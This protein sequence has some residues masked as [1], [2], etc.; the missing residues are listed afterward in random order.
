MNPA[1]ESPTLSSE[2]L[3]ATTP[4]RESADTQAVTSAK[5]GASLKLSEISGSNGFLIAGAAKGDQSGIAVSP[6][7]DVNGDGFADIMIGAHFADPNGNL[8]A[9]SGYVVFGAKKGIAITKNLLALD[10]SDGFVMEGDGSL[11]WAGFSVSTAGDVNNDGFDDL[12]VGARFASGSGGTYAGRSYV[13]FGGNGSFPKSIE[14]AK[15]DGSDGFALEGV[16]DYDQSGRSVAAAGDVNNDGIDDLIVGAYLAS[17]GATGKA[18]AAY[19]VFGR[20]SG[21][22]ASLSLSD[23]D[24][25]DGFTVSGASPKDQAGFAVDGAGDVNGDGID[26]LLVGAPHGELAGPTRAGEAFLVL[27]RDSGFAANFDL[28][29]LD[30]SDGTRFLGHI[31]NGE[32]GGAVAVAGDINGDGLSDIVI[33]AP[34]AQA[35]GDAAAGR[36]Y[37]VFGHRGAQNADLDLSDLDGRNGFTLLGIDSE[38]Y[39]G[40]DVSSA[41]DLNGDGF[42]DLLIGAFGADP[43]GASRAGESYIVFGRGDGN[44]PAALKLAKLDGS[45]GVLLKGSDLNDRS[46]HAVAGLGDVNRDGFDDIIVGA[47]SG[48]PNGKSNSGENYVLFGG[49]DF[50][51]GNTTAGTIYANNLSGKAG[52]DVLLGLSGKDRLKGL[53]G[54]DSL[55][56]GDGGDVLLGGLGN[57]QLFGGRAGDRLLGQAGADDLFGNAG[58]DTLMGGNGPDYLDGG[59]GPDELIGGAGPDKLFGGNQNDTLVGGVGADLLFGQ[60]GA[61]RLEG[62]RQN[63]VLRGGPGAD[64]LLGGGGADRLFGGTGPDTI[65]G[66]GGNDQLQG[67]GGPDI[68][69][70]TT[71]GGEDVVTDF[72]SLTDLLDVSDFGFSSAAEVLAAT[73]NDNGSAVITL[74]V[75]ESVTLDGVLKE[76]LDPADFIL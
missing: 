60:G 24:G 45:D 56:G 58:S 12:I 13:V 51:P 63:D 2:S 31:A 22:P 52:A 18:G 5:V 26:D 25:S 42:D 46:G 36:A 59:T 50:V 23:L 39:A 44:F 1:T 66:G 64:D 35:G 43:G 47:R 3:L 27:G 37:V 40:F 28:G 74:S 15:L 11:D 48:D 72:L 20:D 57:D 53:G 61:D 71:G 29:A 54:A 6:A 49:T 55:Y 76:S 69:I 73:N 62:G 16:A 19:I 10:G 8:D 70:F 38:D 17:P 67:G 30:G 32:T 7:G 75:G 9:G 14:L 21:F 41:G 4:N 68:F 33:G 65:I 34:N